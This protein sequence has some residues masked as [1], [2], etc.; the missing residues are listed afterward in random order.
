MSIRRQNLELG[1]EVYSPHQCTTREP[2]RERGKELE[3]W[4]G[5]GGMAGAVETD[6][7][8]AGLKTLMESSRDTER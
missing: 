3:R 7:S 6:K 5:H 2:E 4:E 8:A 1:Q